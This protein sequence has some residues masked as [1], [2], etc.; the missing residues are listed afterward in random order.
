M[1]ALKIVKRLTGFDPLHNA[2]NIGI[3]PET[4]QG[5]SCLVFVAV[6]QKGIVS[7]V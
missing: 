5:K 2:V 6:Y 3:I 7:Y 4:C 1:I